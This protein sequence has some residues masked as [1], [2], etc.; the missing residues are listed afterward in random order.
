MLE[1]RAKEAGLS[2]CDMLL[3]LSQ[4]EINLL[5]FP[6]QKVKYPV[7]MGARG[8]WLTDLQQTW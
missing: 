4:Y 7:S 1:K 2:V 5:N 6:I 3:N 8:G